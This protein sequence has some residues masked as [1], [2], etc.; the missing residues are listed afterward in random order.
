MVKLGE[1]EVETSQGGAKLG[2][3][4]AKMDKGGVLL[5]ISQGF[6][7]KHSVGPRPGSL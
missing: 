7:P 5:K 1:V 6:L 3:H 2:Q 4:R